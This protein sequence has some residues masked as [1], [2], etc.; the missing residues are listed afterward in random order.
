[1]LLGMSKHSVNKLIHSIITF[2]DIKQF[3]DVPLFT[4]SYG[5]ILRLGFSVAIHADPDILVIDEH[6]TVGDSDFQAKSRE[7][8]NLLFKK[9]L[10][11]VVVSHDPS[12]LNELC[13]R[14]IIL[15]EGKITE[16][17]HRSLNNFPNHR[18][19]HDKK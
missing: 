13:D 17:K 10:T 4:Y 14:I 3:I 9:K 8:L 15:N 6:L 7:R 18:H 12:I 2:A 16:D 11:I 1:M 19:T 5:M